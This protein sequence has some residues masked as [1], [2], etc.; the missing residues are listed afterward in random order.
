[1]RKKL[2]KRPIIFL[3]CA[4]KALKALLT[5]HGNWAWDGHRQGENAKILLSLCKREGMLPHRQFVS[6]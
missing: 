4:W 5:F 6:V 1:M 3:Q 2:A